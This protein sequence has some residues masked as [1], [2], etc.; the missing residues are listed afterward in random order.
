MQ[1]IAYIGYNATG[2][3]P[4]VAP[5]KPDTSPVVS[6]H[7]KPLLH[8]VYGFFLVSFF[9]MGLNKHLKKVISLSGIG[10]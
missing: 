7:Q 8:L 2:L 6:V 4:R 10:R 1:R 9:C 3:C 5:E